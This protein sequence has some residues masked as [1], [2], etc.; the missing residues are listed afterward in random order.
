MTSSHGFHQSTSLFI[1]IHAF[2]NDQRILIGPPLSTHLLIEVV[3]Y[4]IEAK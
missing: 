1:S 4:P 3:F 2:I